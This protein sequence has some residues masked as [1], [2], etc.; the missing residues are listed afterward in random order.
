MIIIT[1]LL[2]NIIGVNFELLHR[3]YILY[4][5]DFFF[6]N[7]IKKLLIFFFFG[8][9][10]MIKFTN[11]TYVTIIYTYILADQNFILQ[12]Y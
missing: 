10:Q 9:Y 4:Y 1:F 5:V 6:I 11:L 2:R 3:F 7:T 8:S 12:K